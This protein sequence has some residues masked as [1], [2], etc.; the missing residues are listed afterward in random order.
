[1]ESLL[2]DMKNLNVQNR[3]VA[4]IENGTWAPQSAKLLRAVLDSM[5]DITYIG[6]PLTV[7]SATVNREALEALADAVAK[8][9]QS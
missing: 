4:L 6:E 9:L 3:K 1:M 5:K 2:T 7:K 8:D